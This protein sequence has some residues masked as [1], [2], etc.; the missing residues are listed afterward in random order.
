MINRQCNLIINE[1]AILKQK[2]IWVNVYL[3]SLLFQ[4]YIEEK[5]SIRI[6]YFHLTKSMTYRSVIPY[7]FMFY[8]SQ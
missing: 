5:E 2:K 8:V 3:K 4:N 7:S 1:W 6:Y